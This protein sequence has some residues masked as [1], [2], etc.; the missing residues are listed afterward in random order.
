MAVAGVTPLLPG[1][2]PTAAHAESS[3]GTASPEFP[4]VR[5]GSATDIFVDAADDPAVIRAA[6]DLQADVE[7]VS[8]TRPRLIHSLPVLPG[9]ATRLVLVGTIGASP[10]IDG[11]IAQGR[12]KV[13]RVK[14]SWEASVTQVVDRPLPGVDRALVIAGSDRRGTIYGIY[15]TS[16]RIGV[17]PWYWWADVPV[18]HR[19]EVT[20]PH[21]PFTRH[22]PSVRFRGI[23]INDEQNLT[24]W[25]HRTQE[26]DK[27]I[28]PETYKHVFE[29]LLRLKANYLWP[30]MHPYS[31]FFNKH[32]ENPELA[33]HY[34]IV[35]GSSHPEALL[36]N[37]VHEWDPWA[38]EHLNAD[39]SLPVYDYTVN[40]AVISDYWRA[41]AR[42][43]AAYESSWTLGM[44]GLHDS[45]LETKNATTIPEKVVVM[46]DI[47]ADQR[48]ILT[49]EVGQAAE[50]QIFIPYKEVLDLYNAGVQVPDDVTLIWPDDNH[51]N[52]RQLPNDA[53]RRRAGGNGIYYHL[54]YWG[55]PKS[56]LWLD[57][58]QLAKVWQELRRVYEHGAD[59]MWI[60]NVGDVKSI[61]T[62][63]SFAMDV[64]WDV[65]RWGAD[66]VED[67]LV[68]WAGRQ[69]GRRHGR[70]IAAIRTEYY[71]LAAELRPEFIAAG[72]ISVIH[73]GDEAGR[74]MAAYEQLLEQ[75]R[76]LGAKLPETYRDAYFELVEYPV[77]GAYLMNLKYYW[78]DRNALA[79]RQGRG[80]GTNRFAD[81]AEA[82]H[83]AEA[84]LTKRYN[85][86]VAGGKWDGIVNPYPSQIPKAPGRPAV[87]RVA[88]QETSGLGVASEGNETGAARPLSFFSGT[89]DRRF[90]DVFNTGFLALSWT[91]EA[92]HPWVR[93]S[94]SGG[95]LTDQARVWVEIDWDR[96]PEGSYEATVTVSGADAGQRVDVPLRVRNDGERALRRRP[97][98][99][100][101][102][103]Y[104]SID[105]AHTD[106]RVT[107]GGAR[108]RTVRGLGRRSGAVEA[109]PSTAAPITADFATRAPELRY[110]VRFSSTGTFPVT[111]FR[112]PSLDERGKRRVAVSLDDQPVTVLS[113]QSVATGNRGDAWARNVEDG[114]E[115]LTATV[116]VTEP[117]EH[118]LR[119]FMVDAAIA[120]DQ[121]VIDTGGLPVSYL[122]PP[123]SYHPV[124]NSGSR[125]G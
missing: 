8:G 53:E 47:I 78:A 105:A 22:E 17:S 2:L 42:Q 90:L 58:T 82:A 14:G 7:R 111:V 6:G 23:F 49:E 94:E 97:G 51:G 48:R 71:R 59:R 91:A 41:R 27:N 83:T 103:G 61:E 93:L 75:A 123:E 10:V 104:V 89:R 109:V 88:R 54:S 37:G 73:H 98:F 120:V 20:V 18:E 101:A 74:R 9:K 12:L 32:R 69:F 80:A 86:E 21:G 63:L 1:L 34:G 79:R 125:E 45:A 44:R 38:A 40:P 29:L 28:G 112:L 30:A 110:R 107:R 121:I 77:H 64:A 19:A 26:P 108:W 99:A 5:A 102:H 35:V 92:S 118:E 16:E 25:S 106:R 96:V 72:L 24:T 39:G 3:A 115:R 11:L 85:T 113:G 43:N 65:D 114:V 60:F 100:E 87:T 31:D 57:T 62:G 119:L 122:A 46:N 70:E 56:Y 13:A 68:E 4:L 15:D 84:A 52:M 76:T 81:L 67:F 55:R 33:E 95:S 124:F 36:R 50:P 116:T 66:D 117:G